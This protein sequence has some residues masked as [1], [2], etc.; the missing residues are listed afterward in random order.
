VQGTLFHRVWEGARSA[1]PPTKSVSGDVAWNGNGE[2]TRAQSARIPRFHN[3]NVA[4]VRPSRLG[5]SV[6]ALGIGITFGILLIGQLQSPVVATTTN[7]LRFSQQTVDRLEAEQAQLKKQIVDARVSAAAEQKQLSQ[8]ETEAAQLSRGLGEQRA[9]AGTVPLKGVG[10]E[11]LLDDSLEHPTLNSDDPNNYIVHEYQIR[12]IVNQLWQAGAVGISVNGERFVN[13]TSVYCVGT[14]ILIN[15]TRTSPPYRI[16]AVGDPTRL[17]T[18]L[19]DGNALTDIKG[20]AL[21]YG[22]VFRITGTGTY[23]LPA[24]AGSISLKNT[25]IEPQAP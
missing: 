8:G 17:R 9:I 14:T 15:D 10:I 6:I 5:G 3:V 4:G 22:L 20:R 23:T 2:A 19:E 25:Q 18:A 24:F 13:S 11:V 7:G 12:D 16:Q 1:S 21:A